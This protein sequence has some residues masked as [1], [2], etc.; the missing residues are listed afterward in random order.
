MSCHPGPDISFLKGMI[1][2]FFPP[3]H[4]LGL[5]A[6]RRAEASKEG[7]HLS[8]STFWPPWI[9]HPKWWGLVREART[10]WQQSKKDC[11]SFDLADV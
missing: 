3:W 10:H 11:I 4:L 8:T 1:V 5:W 2:Q 7:V 9:G 6:R